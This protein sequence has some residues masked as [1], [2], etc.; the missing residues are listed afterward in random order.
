M[1]LRAE[2]TFIVMIV[3]A[4]LDE[5]GHGQKDIF[6]FGGL[7]ASCADAARL[8][9]AWERELRR[10]P[11]ISCIKASEIY[12]PKNPWRSPY[13]EERLSKFVKMIGDHIGGA[14]RFRLPWSAYNIHVLQSRR[15][16]KQPNSPWFFAFY[17]MMFNLIAPYVLNHIHDEFQFIYDC[18][19][20]AEN[21]LRRG[22]QKLIESF[23][24][25]CAKWLAGPPIPADD[26]KVMPLQAADLIAWHTRQAAIRELRGEPNYTDPT[27]EAIKE[28]PAVKNGF[29]EMW[30]EKDIREVISSIGCR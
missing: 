9:D 7:M 16:R 8:S 14:I 3:Q 6:V 21:K 28:L 30:T 10:S 20:G 22:H 17:A 18:Q 15:I 12:N 13:R 25:N 2:V 19:V 27:W 29:D 1:P 11:A 23:P 4:Y 26:K 24:E 5:S